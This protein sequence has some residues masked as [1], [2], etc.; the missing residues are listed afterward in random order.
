MVDKQLNDTHTHST[1]EKSK[2]GLFVFE[3]DLSYNIST[4]SKRT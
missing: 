3:Y 2:S 4:E 1:D